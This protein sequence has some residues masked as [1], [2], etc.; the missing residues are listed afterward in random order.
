MTPTDMDKL[1][2]LIKIRDEAELAFETKGA[3]AHYVE[4]VEASKALKDWLGSKAVAILKH[5]ER[6]ERNRDMWKG[7]CERQAEAL[8][9]RNTALEEIVLSR[10][11]TNKS[12]CHQADIARAALKGPTT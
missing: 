12:S 4:A 11:F 2:E 8:A 10:S 5:V 7:Q 9:K 6:V 3:A 1:R